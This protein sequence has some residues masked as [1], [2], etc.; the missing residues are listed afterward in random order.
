MPPKISV[1]I[2]TYNRRDLVIRAIE[3]VIAQSF[4]D[5]ELI[6]VDDCSTDDSF[7]YLK[8]KYNTENRIS[9]TQPP[10][11][12]GQ[13]AAR[14]FGILKCTAPFIAF[15]DSDDFWH[16]R[17]LEEQLM[18]FESN[19]ISLG[20]VYCGGILSDE[21]NVTGE[22]HPTLKGWIEKSLFL[23]LKGLGSS[24]SGIMIRKE[25]IEKVGNYDTTFKSQMDLDF[26]VRIARYYRIDFINN[27]YTTIYASTTAN[28]ISNNYNS[29]II[30]EC[31]FLD[32]H[33][34]RIKELD[35][36]HYVAR[37]L[38]RKYALYA[39]DLPNAF[40][41]IFK[42]IKYKPT[43]IYAYIYIF[44]LVFLYFKR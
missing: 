22:I 3:S 16:P 36:F 44:K 6:V 5:W 29:V 1:V 42:A 43:Y 35:L 31:Q 41:M 40:R 26:F 27:C 30:G 2:P 7:Q 18:L 38:A 23:N 21:K 32:K 34:E 9:I 33:S 15:L 14:N 19:D 10:K 13:G 37:K 4:K 17:K 8:E 24:N 12:G 39:K 11:N 20:M 28:R 25:V